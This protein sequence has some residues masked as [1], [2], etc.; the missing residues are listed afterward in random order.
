MR[1]EEFFVRGALIVVIAIAIYLYVQKWM[2]HTPSERGLHFN[3]MIL[4]YACWPVFFLGFLLSVV[5]ADI[6]REA[7]WHDLVKPGLRIGVRVSVEV[8]AS[9]MPAVPDRHSVMGQ[10]DAF[11]LD[12]GVDQVVGAAK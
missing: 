8:P 2:S 5:D 12:P 9:M 11:V 4:K 3:G 6:H 7:P 1:F 10:C